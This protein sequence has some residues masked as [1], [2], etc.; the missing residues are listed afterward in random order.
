MTISIDEVIEAGNLITVDAALDIL[1][2]TEP[3]NE[4]SFALD[5][6]D[7]VH[8]T[9]P[10]DWADT[11]KGE[12]SGYVTNCTVDI[13]GSDEIPL[14]TEAFLKMT[15]S[16]GLTKDYVLRTPGAFIEPQLN[17]WIKNGGVKSTDG[18]RLLAKDGVGQAFIKSSLV[19]FPNLP[20]VETVVDRIKDH[21]ETD[22]V[23]VDY[24]LAHSLERTALRF[25]VPSY[26]RTID[27]ARN[28]TSKP[29][30]W[31]LGVQVTNSIMAHP[32][33]KLS[34]SGYLFAWWCTNGAISTHATSGNY[35]RRVSG[36]EISEV[37]DWVGKSTENIF[38]DLGHELDAIADLV[39]VPLQGE[40]NDVIQDVFK[41]FRVAQ[42]MRQPIMDNLIDSSDLTGY[43]LMQAIT[44]S[45][46]GID[47]SDSVRE[48]IMSIG[49]A[50][51]STLTDRCGSC[52]RVKLG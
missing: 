27:S 39:N 8:F 4:Y 5:G 51:P 52:H 44:Q 32:E 22:E 48:S 17:W 50:M 29:D 41:Q 7:E 3:L 21:F 13:N 45:A 28:S 30:N 6:T 15:S 43:G 12:P 25:V 9:V 14:T 2:T 46:N 1:H 20:V 18:M 33:T 11:A 40:I 23:Y 36:Q 26:V 47:V 37:L 24:K 49:G 16:I 38:D 19:T 42:N 31:S 10:T 35:N 34:V